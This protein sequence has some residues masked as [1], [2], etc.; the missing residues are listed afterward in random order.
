MK[1]LLPLLIA[2]GCAHAPGAAPR[3]ASEPADAPARE[4]AHGSRGASEP[5]ALP[6]RVVDGNGSDELSDAALDAKLRAARVIYVG[7]EHPSPHDH[8]A[9]LEVL[10]RAYQADPSIGLGLEMLPR[11]LQGS[12]DAYVSGNLD[13]AGFLRAVD[14]DKTWGYP[15]GLYRPLLEFCRA[16]HLPA[17]A[18]NAPHELAHVVAFKGLDALSDEQKRALPQL[19]PGPPAHREQVREAFAQ[20]PHSRFDGEEFERFYLAQLI[21]DETM[22]ERVAAALGPGGPAHLVVI[23][24][25][26]HTR[27]FAIPDRAARRGAAPYLTI[28]PVLDEDEADARADKAA[29]V[30]WVLKTR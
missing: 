9:E 12:L 14:W 22:A 30:L 7:E 25:S 20:H 3:T 28:L 6:H 4:H 24:G 5:I 23:A 1:R 11:T 8:A 26:G 13:E 15:W 16:H 27:R 2:A 10:E 17:F 21:W 18:L 29:D 19:E